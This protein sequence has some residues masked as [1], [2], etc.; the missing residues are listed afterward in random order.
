MSQKVREHSAKR[1]AD[2]FPGSKF[3]G[4]G[5]GSAYFQSTT[6]RPIRDLTGQWLTSIPSKRRRSLNTPRRGWGSRVGDG[7]CFTLVDQA[8]RAAGTRS[9]ARCGPITPNANY[10]WGRAITVGQAQ[11]ADVIQF[12]NYR[13]VRRVTTKI[14]RADGSED[15][16]FAE[17]EQ[18]RP[19]H[20]A[21]VASRR[22]PGGRDGARAKR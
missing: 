18:S 5:T 15:E 6:S 10:I 16:S 1:G 17:E 11:A 8:L 12:S 7:E 13:Y 21:I 4:E 9:A 3:K 19:H 14:V 20:T 2:Y 22:Q